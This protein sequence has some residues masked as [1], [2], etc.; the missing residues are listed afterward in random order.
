MSLAILKNCYKSSFIRFH[1]KIIPS[2][3]KFSLI[4]ITRLKPYD[5][6]LKNASSDLSVYT[7]IQNKSRGVNHSLEISG[8]PY[9]KSE[10]SYT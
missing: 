6:P 5:F 3:I 9:K 1:K 4:R 8:N 7:S 10:I 2:R